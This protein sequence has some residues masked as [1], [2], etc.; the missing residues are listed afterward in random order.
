MSNEYDESNI[1]EEENDE[2][3]DIDYEVLDIIEGVKKGEYETIFPHI[4]YDFANDDVNIPESGIL[5]RKYLQYYPPSA[6]NIEIYNN[7][8]FNTFYYNIHGRIVKI[9]TKIKDRETHYVKFENPSLLNPFRLQNGVR[10]PLT[11]QYCRKNGKTYEITA[12]CNISLYKFMNEGED[13][14]VAGPIQLEI[15]KIPLMIKSGACVLYNKTTQELEEYGEDPYEPGGY[16]IIK[17]KEKLILNQEQMALNKVYLSVN[18]KQKL[19][20]RIICQYEKKNTIMF[21]MVYND[22]TKIIE[23]EFSSVKKKLDDKKV[24]KND[25]SDKENVSFNILRLLRFFGIGTGIYIDSNGEK[26]VSRDKARKEIR[27]EL[28]KFVPNKLIGD[29][30]NKLCMTLSDAFIDY[31]SEY[32]KARKNDYRYLFSLLK[33]N[34][35]I[36]KSGKSDEDEKEEKIIEEY[37]TR[38]IANDVFPQLNEIPKM[39]NETIK[40]FNERI[41]AIRNSMIV[42]MLAKMLLNLSGHLK[43]SDRD[44][45]SN[46][47]VD[48]AGKLMEALFKRAFQLAQT[49]IN[50]N[51]QDLRITDDTDA[52]SILEKIRNYERPNNKDSS[53]GSIVTTTFISSFVSPT[54]GLKG[55]D[56]KNNIVQILNREGKVATFSHIDNLDVNVPRNSQQPG[57]R[58]VQ[59]TQYGFICAILASESE[60]CGLLKAFCLTTRLSLDRRDVY[61]T[62]DKIYNSKLL[63]KKSSEDSN[64]R[65]YVNGFHLGWCN[66]KKMK[67]FLL[68]KRRNGLLHFDTSIIKHRDITGKRIDVETTPSRVLRPLLV[69]EDGEL[70]L[71]KL[72]MRNSSIQQMLDSG[73]IEYVSAWEQEYIKL[74]SSEKVLLKYRA[75]KMKSEQCV[76]ELEDEILILKKKN[77]LYNDFIKYDQ[78]IKNLKDKHEFNLIR[79]T[80]KDLKNYEN[81]YAKQLERL[82]NEIE[83]IKN[84]NKNVENIKDLDKKLEVERAH[85]NQLRKFKPYTHCEIDALATMGIAASM[86]PLPNHS[87]APRN[88]YQTGM[89]K[90]ALSNPHTNSRN[91][92]EGKIK[93]LVNPERP[94]FETEISSIMGLDIT[95]TGF[96]CKLAFLADPYNQ[97]D[98]FIFKKQFIEAGASRMRKTISFVSTL[99]DKEGIE[100]EFSRPLNI[101]SKNIHRY[102]YIMPNGLPCIGA[103]LDEKD[104][105]IGKIRKI[106]G[107][108]EDQSTFLKIGEKGVV[109]SVYVS[110]STVK[111]R[112]SITRIPTIGDKFSPRNAQKSTI[113]RIESVENLPFNENTGISPDIET[114]THQIPSR[115]TLSY[116]IE[117]CLSKETSYTCKRDNATSFRDLDFESAEKILL[118]KGYT[119]YGYEQY[120]SGISGRLFKSPTSVGPCF[121][122]ALKHHPADKIQGRSVG[123][124][125][126]STRQPQGGRNKGGGLRFGEMERDAAV[127]WGATSV[128]QERLCLLSDAYNIVLCRKCGEFA[129][130]RYGGDYYCTNCKGSHNDFGVKTIPWVYTLLVRYCAAMGINLGLQLEFNEETKNNILQPKINKFEIGRTENT[131]MVDLTLNRKEELQEESK[132]DEVNLIDINFD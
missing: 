72:K 71:D 116:P 78:E 30:M 87:Q 45:W 9:G 3:I 32:E 106:S 44:S 115:M 77:P 70:V 74:A 37:V 121:F 11:P 58:D 122:Q 101:N 62:Y 53:V 29:C 75:E 14:L 60:N 95:G 108:I 55:K 102:K 7:W 124:I 112:I 119:K 81:K 73:C 69:V 46:K 42:E 21:Q 19:I 80:G 48:S 107:E 67:K 131:E 79:Y 105:V 5:L 128:L 38:I 34:G 103:P 86:I 50:K 100:E 98:A 35:K 36:I 52:N 15:G 8:L 76:A 6:R 129:T 127:S 17:G 24:Q 118:E 26:M 96:N 68:D 64:T 33:N 12:K 120:R 51:F 31:S 93:M 97:E 109:E 18:K 28:K 10:I 104:C 92:Y 63:L 111:V 16:F 65:I 83:K 123:P 41:E 23:S 4:E 132:I 1:E 66:G 99:T 84:K 25:G 113:G 2:T 43:L 91:R 57:I 89:S 13:K 22:Q 130:H 27:D 39:N 20:C 126:S 110:G 54:W 82:E 90:Q 88:T 125:K 56:G 94:L 85:L 47:K 114:N 117:I 40:Q 49:S 61:I 59:Q